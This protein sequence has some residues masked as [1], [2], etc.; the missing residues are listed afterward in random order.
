MKFTTSIPGL[1][2][3]PGMGGQPEWSKHMTPD[4]MHAIVE[5]ADANGIDHLVVPW[6]M[7]I[8]AGEWERNMGPRWPH[9]LATAGWVLG[10]TKRILVAPLVV[11]PCHHPVELAKGLASLDWIS[12]GRCLPVILSGYIEWEFN[13]LGADFARRDDVTDEYIEAMYELWESDRPTF[14]GEFVSF[15]D[16][17]C[18]PRPR[19]QPFPLWIGGRARKSLRRIA[20]RGAGW[21]SYGLRTRR[22]Q[23]RSST[24][25]HAQTGSSATWTSSPTSSSRLTTRSRTA[26]MPRPHVPMGEQAVLEQLERLKSLGINATNAP[27]SSYAWPGSREREPT[28]PATLEEYLERLDWLGD[29]IIPAAAKLLPI[30]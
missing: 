14:S 17:L 11:A 19:Q 28:A 23:R 27:L 7:A 29:V 2:L 4:Q 18:E 9:A 13:L 24:S 26:K 5:R 20:R 1:T 16:A 12:G 8:R 6:H 30:R 25:A 15:E 22:F 10:G 21:M 3:F